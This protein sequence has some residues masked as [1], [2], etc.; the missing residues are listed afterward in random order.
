LLKTKDL[1]L[2]EPEFLSSDLPDV[3]YHSISSLQALKVEVDKIPKQDLDVFVEGWTNQSIA[4]QLNYALKIF[5]DTFQKWIAIH[6]QIIKDKKPLAVGEIIKREEQM[7]II[8]P[9]LANGMK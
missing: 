8:M 2:V 7:G 3:S 5:K 6:S 4:W 1:N 9:S